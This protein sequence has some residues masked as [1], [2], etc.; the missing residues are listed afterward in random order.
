MRTPLANRSDTCDLSGSHAK[1]P[2]LHGGN[3]WFCND[4]F[5]L[6]ELQPF[7]YAT[8]APGM[9]SLSILC[10]WTKTVM[11]LEP[12]NQDYDHWWC[13][14]MYQYKSVCMIRIRCAQKSY[15]YLCNPRYVNV[16]TWNTPSLLSI[17]LTSSFAEN[18]GTPISPA[19]KHAAA[20]TT[21]AK[22]HWMF[23][24]P[25]IRAPTSPISCEWWRFIGIITS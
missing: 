22:G 21:L 19:A 4:D 12:Y 10:P 5:V 2:M 3:P 20:H 14:S 15:T 23:Q 17:Y 16:Y 18:I 13:T 6:P 7:S 9:R 24:G 8:R 11:W 1:C 25:G